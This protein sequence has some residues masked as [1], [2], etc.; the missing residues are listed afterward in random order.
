MFSQL[1]QEHC[2]AITFAFGKPCEDSLEFVELLRG[3]REWG[4][5]YPFHMTSHRLGPNNHGLGFV[6]QPCT[7]FCSLESIGR[8]SVEIISFSFKIIHSHCGGSSDE[9]VECIHNLFHNLAYFFLIK[10]G[11]GYRIDLN[12]CQDPEP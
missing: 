3:A 1:S 6:T 4:N 11:A 8:L 9:V 12:G 2:R 10:W 7:L 5:G